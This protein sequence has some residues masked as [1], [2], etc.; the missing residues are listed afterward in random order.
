MVKA[1]RKKILKDDKCKYI[2]GQKKWDWTRAP[3]A[4][5]QIM[6]AYCSLEQLSQNPF[7]RNLVIPVHCIDTAETYL[8]AVD[9]IWR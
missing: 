5:R 6:W 7:L 1:I 8:R 9:C 2:S 4:P 3:Q